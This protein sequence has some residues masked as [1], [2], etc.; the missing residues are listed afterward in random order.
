MTAF[1][2]MKSLSEIFTFPVRYCNNFR[3][4]ASPEQKLGTAVGEVTSCISPHFQSD[5][6]VCQRRGGAARGRKEAR[7]R[8]GERVLLIAL[9]HSCYHEISLLR[10]KGL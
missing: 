3:F 6:K 5:C 7:L 9:P 1:V 8:E 4:G 2:H 10:T